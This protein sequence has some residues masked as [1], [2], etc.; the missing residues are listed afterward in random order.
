M[1]LTKG[2]GIDFHFNWKF[3]EPVDCIGGKVYFGRY[4]VINMPD[5]NKCVDCDATI[6]ESKDYCDDCQIF[7]ESDGVKYPKLKAKI[8]WT[9]TSLDG[10]MSVI[11]LYRG[12][13]YYGKCWQ[14]AHT[15]KSR[16]YW[17]YLLSPDE[18]QNEIKY[19]GLLKTKSR[20][21]TYTQLQEQCGIPPWRTEYTERKPIG[22][23]ALYE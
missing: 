3:W 16:Y 19:K 9:L 10:P 20:D 15:R 7:Y 18:A 14:N 11:S 8:A 2:C 12:S 6:S 22:Y 21:T 5:E 1:G 4:V 17:M 13:Y 23:F